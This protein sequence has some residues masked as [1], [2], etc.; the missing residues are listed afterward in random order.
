MQQAEAEAGS[1][2]ETANRARFYL[3]RCQ[4]VG[5]P[6]AESAAAR[7]ATA[8][9]VQVA[10]VRSAAAAD[11]LMRSLVASGYE[12]RVVREPDGL[13]KVRVGRFRT[14]AEAQR[15][16]QDL[17]RKLGGNPFVVEEAQQP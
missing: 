7:P 8:F 10:A 17:R 15:L 6:P 12:P 13:L 5:P 2:V 4:A 16:A 9:S 3:Q 11:E 14:R 1:D